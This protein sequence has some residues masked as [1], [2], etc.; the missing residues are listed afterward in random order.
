MDKSGHLHMLAI[1]FPGKTSQ[2]PIQEEEE[3]EVTE[4]QSESK[5]SKRRKKSFVPATN[6]AKIP[7][8]FSPQS[9]HYS[10]YAILAISVNYI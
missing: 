4:P 1:L 8:P 2:K 5:H 3:E 10:K 6:Q 9:S 7:Q